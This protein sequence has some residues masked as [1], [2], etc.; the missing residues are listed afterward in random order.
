MHVAAY[1]ICILLF[2][3]NSK[4][5]NIHFIFEKRNWNSSIW[6]ILMGLKHYTEPLSGYALYCMWKQVIILCKLWLIA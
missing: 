6:K 2:P 4:E 3:A 5:L 1:L